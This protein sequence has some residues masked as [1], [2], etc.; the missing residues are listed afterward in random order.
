[1]TITLQINPA[2]YNLFWQIEQQK[3]EEIRRRCF[4]QQ[5]TVV[6]LASSGVEAE[7]GELDLDQLVREKEEEDKKNKPVDEEEEDKKNKP[8]DHLHENENSSVVVPTN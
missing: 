8:V 4:G 2:N 1:M 5:Q 7:G 3:D 6:F